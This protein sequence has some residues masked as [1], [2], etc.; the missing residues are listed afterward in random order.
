MGKKK[1]GK[2]VFP[3][4]AQVEQIRQA[5]KFLGLYGS[6]ASFEYIVAKVRE[7]HGT[8]FD[9]LEQLFRHEYDYQEEA[10][11]NRRIQQGKLVP[12]NTIQEYDFTLQPS[13]DPVQ[14]HELAS[15]RFITEGKNVIFLGSPGVGKTH[16]A[17]ALAYEAIK[18]GYETRCMKLNE[19]INVVHR[20]AEANMSRLHRS[21]SS[22]DLLILDDIDYY[23]TDEESDKFLFDVVKQRY[24]DKASTII[25]SN[26]NPK[27][28]NNIFGTP[29]RAEAALDRLFDHNRA[30]VI[31]IKGGRSY[32]TP[33]ALDDISGV[34]AAAPQPSKDKGFL[35]KITTSFV[36]KV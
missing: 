9:L 16:L 2:F 24:E 8:G 29:E 6:A 31:R 35:K 33:E 21:L 18:Q 20:T 11:V 12:L 1:V 22:P 36:Q 30:V 27:E 17:V 5:M 15:C 3:N 23:T 19:F 10:R 4:G 14:L 7:E 28:W 25:T 26:K 34:Q 13:I 32:R